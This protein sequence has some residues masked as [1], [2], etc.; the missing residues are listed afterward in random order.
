MKEKKSEK[1]TFIRKNFVVFIALAYLIFLALINS[2]GSAS[3]DKEKVIDSSLV[4]YPALINYSSRGCSCSNMVPALEAI[5]NQYKK[6]LR[7]KDM[8]VM[9]SEEAFQEAKKAGIKTTPTQIFYDING[10]EVFR[11]EGPMSKH[12]IEKLLKEKG[13]VK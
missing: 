11:H 8:N 13:L 2:T 6:V 10:K 12:D 3:S 5:V 7:V 1:V 4:T 9:D